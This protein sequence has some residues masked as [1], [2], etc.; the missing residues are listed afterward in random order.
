MQLI[1]ICSW[2]QKFMRFKKWMGD[3][4]PVYPVSHSICP[5]CKDK[6]DEELNNNKGGSYERERKACAG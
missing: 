5:T 4:P 3:K 2:C 1:V 6:L